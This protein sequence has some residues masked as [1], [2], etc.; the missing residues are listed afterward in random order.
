[1]ADTVTFTATI[2]RRYVHSGGWLL[3]SSFVQEMLVRADTQAKGK[4][5]KVRWEDA[6]W[7]VSDVV[8]P[9]HPNRRGDV[10]VTLTAVP[11]EKPKPGD[12]DS[13]PVVPADVVVPTRE[14]PPKPKDNPGRLPGPDPR[15]H[16]P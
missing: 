8:D 14:K 6:T 16:T 2:P 12:P 9:R 3:L 4:D 1:M 10:L 15:R 7:S 11:S 5:K 13:G